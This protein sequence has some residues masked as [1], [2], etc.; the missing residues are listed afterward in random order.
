MTELPAPD[1]RD[2]IRRTIP[3]EYLHSLADGILISALLT[4]G[5][6]V[7]RHGEVPG[8]VP[9]VPALLPEGA[10]CRLDQRMAQS[11]TVV[12]ELPGLLISVD[13]GLGTTDIEVVG[14]DA[15]RVEECLEGL[16]RRAAAAVPTQEGFV[17]MRF[18]TAGDGG[19]LM[20]SRRVETPAWSAVD[21][22]YPGSTGQQLASLMALEDMA[23]RSGRLILW[24][25]APGTGKTTA[26]RALA[27]AWSPWCDTHYVLDPEALFAGSDYLLTV[28]GLTDGPEDDE[29][30]RLIIAED[31]DEYL[32]ADA[33]ARAGASLGRLL[34]LC[35]G[36]L[37][38]GLRVLVLLTTNEDVGQLHPAIVRPG[39]CLSRIE[40]QPFT[41]LQADAW[42]DGV[43][44]PA[45]DSM[46]L[47]E[48]YALREQRPA[49][50]APAPPEHGGY[51]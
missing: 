22:N 13:C 6:S 14:S 18:W 48:L 33:R 26:V 7:H 29:K 37:G 16:V 2:D 41:R 36:I 28:A 8:P 32:R 9:S 46:T 19:G 51:L 21:R 17:R 4:G 49:T 38:H 40:F 12:A 27:R 47:A 42:L 15:A 39:R 43:A 34:N 50:G 10:V 31:C 11:H 23:A 25:G 45:G 1:D 5:M 30:W 44:H 20:S 3:A 24:H 35:D